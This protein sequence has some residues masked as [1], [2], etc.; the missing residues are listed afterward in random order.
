[1]LKSKPQNSKNQFISDFMKDR[2]LRLK[3]LSQNMSTIAGIAWSL[4]EMAE[5]QGKS[6]TSLEYNISNSYKHVESG[7]KELIKASP[8]DTCNRS[9]LMCS[10]L[11]ISLVIMGLAYSI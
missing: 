10:L 3:K 5:D 7:K 9:L 11:V 6:L 4:N 2:T 1:M 8:K